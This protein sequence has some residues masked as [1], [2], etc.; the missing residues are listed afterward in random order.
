ML[1]EHILL[2]SENRMLALVCT[3]IV[4]LWVLLTVFLSHLWDKATSGADGT[5]FSLPIL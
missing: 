3:W 2:A 4:G 5:L 1:R